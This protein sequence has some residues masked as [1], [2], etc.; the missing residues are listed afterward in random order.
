MRTFGLLLVSVPTVDIGHSLARIFL[1]SSTRATGALDHGVIALHT[2][3]PNTFLAVAVH[4]YRSLFALCCPLADALELPDYKMQL[5]LIVS[6]RTGNLTQGKEACRK[7]T[8]VY[9]AAHRDQMS[10]RLASESKFCLLTVYGIFAVTFESSRG[11]NI[12]INP[13]N[14]AGC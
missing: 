12:L 11:E 4:G 1:S 13:N 7:C 5:V 2:S 14:D 3:R 6:G 8:T 10:L 9:R